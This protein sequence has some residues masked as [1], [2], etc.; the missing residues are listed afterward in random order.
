[1]TM[2]SPI[3]PGEALRQKKTATLCGESNFLS[4]SAH[5]LSVFP[6]LWSAWFDRQIRTLGLGRRQKKTPEENAIE[7]HS[8]RTHT[9]DK[10]M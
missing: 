3:G 10:H 9:E 1:M 4:E 5:C 8:T 2:V 7:A 6:V